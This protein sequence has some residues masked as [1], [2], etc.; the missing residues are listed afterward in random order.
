MPAHS[1]L[2][3]KGYIPRLA[4]AL[5]AEALANSG[6]VEICGA[7]WTGKSWTARAF[8][9]DI[10]RVDEDPG[11]YRA[12][13]S[14][15]LVGERG[16]SPLVID[17]WQD[18]PAIWNLVRRRI[19]DK[20]NAPGQFILTGSS[21]PADAE[22][23]HS[24]AGRIVRVR[25]RPM[26]LAETGH[27]SAKVSLAGL[28]A[29]DFSPAKSGLGLQEIAALIHRG[30][31]PA[32]HGN[33]QAKPGPVIEDYLELLFTV[34]MAKAGR[35]PALARKLARSLAR[36]TA[37]SATLATI[38][39]DAA[40]GEVAPS[41]DATAAYLEDFAR[42]FFVN[43]LPGWDAP[44]RAKSRLRT[45]PKRWLDDPSLAASL[46]GADAGRLLQDS[47]L[48]GLLF[49]NLCL[50]D[51]SVYASL[52]PHAGRAPLRY[53]ADADGLEV[54]VIIELTDGRWAG[55]EIKLGED[56]VGEGVKNLK[57]LRAKIAANPA[58]RNPAPAFMA[59]LLGRG[60]AARHLKE[61][62]VYVVPVG[63][64]GA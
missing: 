1:P 16:E 13:P 26:T 28:F 35:N 56:K 54:D 3:P 29:G 41:V 45:K 18:A 37:T 7:R 14:L 53:Y 55:I 50:R 10:V 17:E 2:K 21:T 47:Q 48:L 64:L 11:L 39:Q 20:A 62:D 25:M 6:G 32:L 24:G 63:A 42:N 31:W 60:A 9:R 46:L 19:D 61:D 49:E 44:V 40:A 38:A 52:L 36:N 12:D 4:D 57:R 27:S 30:G 34:S 58:A 15:A 51:L 5:V 33:P 23:R 59:V 43:E 22:D 8:G